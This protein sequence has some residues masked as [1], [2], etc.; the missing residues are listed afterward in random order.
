MNKRDYLDAIAATHA[1]GWITVGCIPA[2]GGR[3]AG[4]YGQVSMG[5]RISNAHNYTLRQVAG[6]PPSER[7]HAAHACRMKGCVNP[8]HLAWK[9]RHENM[10]D[11]RKDGTHP[12]GEVNGRSMLTDPDV[13]EIRRL[14]ATGNYTQQALA[15]MY[16][17]ARITISAIVRRTRW[18]HL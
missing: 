3:T 8:A 17:V 11:K 12:G 18:T 16:G 9:S 2:P 4:G 14:Y 1:S 10:H 5:R 6:E 13:L 15:D 7:P